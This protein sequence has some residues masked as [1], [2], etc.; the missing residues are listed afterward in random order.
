MSVQVVMSVN[1]LC[2]VKH[3]SLF[4]GQQRFGEMLFNYLQGKK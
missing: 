3:R 2:A 4:G 1:I